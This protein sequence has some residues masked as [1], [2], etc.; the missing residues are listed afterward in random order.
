M[1]GLEFDGEIGWYSGGY[2]GMDRRYSCLHMGCNQ[3]GQNARLQKRR[4][5]EVPGI[6][7]N[8]ATPLPR[9][10]DGYHT[11]PRKPYDSAHKAQMFP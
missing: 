3:Y 11:P 4:S 7:T 1:S 5:A 8:G 6:L 10:R 2:V 9:P